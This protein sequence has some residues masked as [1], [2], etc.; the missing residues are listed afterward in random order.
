MSS[1]LVEHYKAVLADLQRR[2]DDYANA[3][4]ELDGMIE[5]INRQIKVL[6]A[7]PPLPANIP[8][9]EPLQFV[10]PNARRKYV[11]ISVRWAVLNFLAE[12]A[13][14]PRNTA[15]IAQAL[16][17]GGVRSEGQRFNSIVS[18]VLSDMK[19]KKEE[20]ETVDDGRYQ[21]TQ[22]GR[23]AWDHIKQTA[24]YR[25]R[26]VSADNSVSRER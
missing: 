23:E 5:G 10:I 20:V 26:G 19:N 21:L 16:Q 18:A 17:E 6:E 14:G 2:R 4:N 7:L 3:I 25:N 1:E 22:R 15:E 24:Q 11:G 9:S 12:D 8:A 13:K